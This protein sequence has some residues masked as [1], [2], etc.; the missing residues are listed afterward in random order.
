MV[1]SIDPA[2]ACVRSPRQEVRPPSPGCSRNGNHARHPG[3]KAWRSGRLGKDL[4]IPVT[5]YAYGNGTHNLPYFQRAFDRS[6]PL[7]LK[8]LGE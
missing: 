8:T 1:G 6:F 3:P 4:K 5:V 7:I 2:N